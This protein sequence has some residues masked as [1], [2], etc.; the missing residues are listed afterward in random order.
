MT[1]DQVNNEIYQFEENDRLGVSY[2]GYAV[3]L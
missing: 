3:K 2:M 1:V